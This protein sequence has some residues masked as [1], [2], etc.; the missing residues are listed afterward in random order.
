MSPDN[1]SSNPGVLSEGS[2]SSSL[3]RRVK[4]RDQEAWQ[5][6]VDL[7]GPLVFSWCRQTGLNETDAADVLQE[8]FAAVSRGIEDFRH[9]RAG[10]TFRGW[11][12]TIA[13]NKIRDH[14]RKQAGQA[15]ATGGTDAQQRLA[16]IPESLSSLSSTS[17]GR[18]ETAALFHRALSA[19]RPEFAE[20]TWRAF[21]RAVVEEEPTAQI[22][23]ELGI[24]ANAVRQAKSRVLRRL[25]RELGDRDE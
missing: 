16:D 24:S 8:V 13:R 1:N 17:R 3:I 2:T 21:W 12:W 7:Y 11:L 23:A 15:A 4:C 14:Y 22:A 6:L 25:R 18:N 9:D 19:V 5:R 20:R 10:D